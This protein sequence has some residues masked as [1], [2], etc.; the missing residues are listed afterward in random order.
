MTDLLIGWPLEPYKNSKRAKLKS[1]SSAKYKVLSE[2]RRYEH[3][4][5]LIT[6]APTGAGKGVRVIIPN[7]LALRWASPLP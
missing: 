2:S 7:L 4:G 6:F 5:H 3:D 1:S